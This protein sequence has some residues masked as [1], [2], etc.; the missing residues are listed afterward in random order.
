MSDVERLIP[1]VD[2][3]NR[4]IPAGTVGNG[5][6]NLSERS[7]MVGNVVS[8]ARERSGMDLV[9]TLYIVHPT[10]SP[11]TVCC[12]SRENCIKLTV[13]IHNTRTYLFILSIKCF[14]LTNKQS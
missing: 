13:K 2:L 5:N 10:N 8:R 7:G 6:K 12:M 14:N 11:V 4:G 3:G 1:A 9:Q